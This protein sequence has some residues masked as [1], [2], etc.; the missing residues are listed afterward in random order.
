MT[1]MTLSGKCRM[2]WR[3]WRTCSGGLETGRWRRE[4]TL[5]KHVLCWS[6]IQENTPET[7]LFWR[8]DI[9]LRSVKRDQP[10]NVSKST[11]RF[12]NDPV[13][14][15]FWFEDHDSDEKTYAHFLSRSSPA[16]RRLPMN[17]TP[18]KMWS[19]AFEKKGGQDFFPEIHPNWQRWL[20]LSLN[21]CYHRDSWRWTDPGLRGE[22]EESKEGSRRTL[23]VWFHWVRK[24]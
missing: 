19:P 3:M 13:T 9:K 6:D 11:A 21:L 12:R 22:K 14:C 2:W 15:P 23:Q 1:M 5:L 8:S 7:C 18:V 24:Q 10:A 17:S 16:V 4:R 20:S